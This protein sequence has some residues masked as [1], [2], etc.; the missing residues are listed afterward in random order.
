[1]TRQGGGRVG[2]GVEFQFSTIFF[3]I[4][5][6]LIYKTMLFNGF[7]HQIKPKYINSLQIEMYT[8]VAHVPMI[9]GRGMGF[10]LSTACFT[11]FGHQIKQ[12]HINSF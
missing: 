12:K 6:R 2:E 1:M 3:G 4:K 10:Q 5:T 7:D 8:Y 11:G 9:R